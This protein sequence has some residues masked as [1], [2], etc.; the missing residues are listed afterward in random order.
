MGLYHEIWL[1]KTITRNVNFYFSAIFV[2]CGILLN[3]VTIL[4]FFSSKQSRNTATS[5]MRTFYIVLAVFDTLALSNSLLFTQL[6]P[7]IGHSIL[8]ESDAL[9]KF[10]SIWTRSVI[11]SPSWI[12]VI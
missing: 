12:Q 8:T 3:L 7:S 1:I 2:P 5:S 10:A 11:Y 4:I 6:L 9:C